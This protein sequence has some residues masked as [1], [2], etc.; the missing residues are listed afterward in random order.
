MIISFKEFRTALWHVSISMSSVDEETIQNYRN[1]INNMYKWHEIRN[2]SLKESSLMKKQYKSFTG[3]KLDL[4]LQEVW[5]NE[6][7]PSYT[8]EVYNNI[9][10][11]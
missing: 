7:I 8:S 9:H 3:K 10:S 5:R 6:I 4:H 2:S 11:N 1:H